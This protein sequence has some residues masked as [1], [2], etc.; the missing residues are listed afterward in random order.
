MPEAALVGP[1]PELYLGT[2][3]EPRE[4]KT[5]RI[6]CPFCGMMA[7]LRRLDDAPYPLDLWVQVYGGPVKP[8][9]VRH[10]PTGRTIDH[11]RNRRGS[12]QYFSV[13]TPDEARIISARAL[14]IAREIVRRAEAG[15]LVVL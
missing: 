8:G 6:H 2:P 15:T 14:E 1:L 10:L 3:L 9:V 12:I 11:T 5:D 7:D 4:R 13:G